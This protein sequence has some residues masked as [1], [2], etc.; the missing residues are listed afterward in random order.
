VQASCVDA[1][2]KNYL[3][4]IGRKGGHKGKGSPLRKELNRRAALIR[5][6]KEKAASKSGEE[7]RKR[8][9]VRIPPALGITILELKRQISRMNIR[10]D[11]QLLASLDDREKTIIL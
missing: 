4:E 5:W 3:A 6:G 9:L 1:V 7:P 2:V 11:E 10:H 8:M